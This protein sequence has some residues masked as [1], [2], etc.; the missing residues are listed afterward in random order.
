MKRVAVFFLNSFLPL[1][2]LSQ[3]TIPPPQP[4]CLS[5]DTLHWAL[6]DPSACGSFAGYEV[7]RS[8]SATGPFALIATVTDQQ[9]T[10]YIDPNPSSEMRYYFMRSLYDCPGWEILSSDT[11]SNAFPNDVTISFVSVENGQVHVQWADNQSPQTSAYLIYRLIG[12]NVDLIDTVFNSLDYVDI[13]ADPQSRSETYYILAMDPCGNTS[14]FVSPH[15][16][17]FLQVEQDFCLRQMQLSWN[18]YEGWP[19]VSSY[20]VWV[21]KDGEPYALAASLPQGSTTYAFQDLKTGS[22]YCFYVEAV[23][24]GVP[25]S[26]AS[27]EV[28][29]SANVAAEPVQLALLNASVNPE[30][31]VEINW[32]W[33]EEI[34]YQSARLDWNDGASISLDVSSPLSFF[35]S[36]LHEQANPEKAPQGYALWVENECGES[37]SGGQVQTI[38]LE[39]E[40]QADG[41]LLRWTAFSLSHAE[42]SAYKLYREEE[43]QWQLVQQLGPLQF[44]F[45]DESVEPTAT[46][47]YRLEAL[48]QLDLPDGGL[49]NGSSFSNLACAIPEVKV[50]LPNVFAPEG[51][52]NR[53]IPGFSAT[54]L[55]SGYELQIFD[56]YGQLVFQTDNPQ[57]GWDGSFRGRPMPMDTY[58]YR[59]HLVTSEGKVL[60]K[61]G[62]LV[63]L[64]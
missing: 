37:F 43:G 33:D 30:G 8:T 54:S 56:R 26:S 28:C 31:Q 58:V 36:Y 21:S 1:V 25:Y 50:Y 20:Q 29:L 15:R 41:V 60:E 22:D 18:A 4:L 45:F 16:T 35:G 24:E 59:L 39:A 6:P 40:A 44:E 62:S 52:N 3:N 5:G 53:F 11:V 57:L 64:R 46:S 47:C 32:Q 27:N 14:A 61:K 48:Y 9:S 7:Y 63:L 2:L 23:A 19:G 38:F 13:G 10:Q 49:Y 51:T 42:V 12:G 17:I 55:L 34:P